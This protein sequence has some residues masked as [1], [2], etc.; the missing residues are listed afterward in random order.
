MDEFT[1][2]ELLKK[3]DLNGLESLVEKYYIQAVRGRMS[4][5]V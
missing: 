4:R 5:V 2:I 3:G 1:A